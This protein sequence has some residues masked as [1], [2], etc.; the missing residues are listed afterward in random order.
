MPHTSY[1]PKNNI[2]TRF[3][4]G[5]KPRKSHNVLGYRELS[6]C[7]SAHYPSWEVSVLVVSFVG[8]TFTLTV[9]WDGYSS[10]VGI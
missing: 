10:G 5:N 3:N 7:L 1:A 9:F 2:N 6:V 8:A 4:A